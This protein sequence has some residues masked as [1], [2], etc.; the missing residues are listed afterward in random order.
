MCGAMISRNVPMADSHSN[1]MGRLLNA[2][3]VHINDGLLPVVVSAAY[4]LK[5]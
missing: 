1:S 5:T 2:P 3:M 4:G